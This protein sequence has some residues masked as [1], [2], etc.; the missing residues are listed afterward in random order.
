MM[1]ALRDNMK[2]I[3]WITAVIF[4]VGFGILE[5][6]G[7]LDQPGNL[8][9]E[10]GVIAKV[11]G[12]P[13][14]YDEFMQVYNRMIQDLTAQ[15]PLQEG[16]DSL[17]REQAWQQ[18]VRNKLMEQ[19]ARRRGIEVTPDEIKTAIRLTPPD[20]LMQ[21]PAFQTD[22]Q[23]DYRKYLGELDN[24]N[25]QLP[26]QQV[27]AVVAAAL[28]TQ[29]LQDQIVAAAKVSEGDVRDRFLLEREQL[30]LR[31]LAFSPDSFQ[32]DTTRIGGADIENYYKAH[33][34]EFTGPQEVKVQ[35]LLAPRLPG[36]ADF[37]AARERLQGILD[38]LRAEPDSFESFARTY[39]DIQSAAAGGDPG[40][41]PYLD[42]LRPIFRNAL[43]TV[44]EGDLSPILQEVRSLHIFRVDRR[45][46]D[47]TTRR[48]RI[49]YHEIAV[50]VLPG[51][52]SIRAARE[53]VAQIQKEAKRQGLSPVATRRGL[54]TFESAFFAQGRSQTAVFQ[55]FPEVELW[56]FR[57][58]VGDVS[59]P[60][61]AEAGWYLYE[62]LDRRNAGKRTLDAVREA[63]KIALIRSLKTAKAEEAA[64]QAWASIL[65]GMPEEEAAR[66]HGGRFIVAEAVK[67]NGIIQGFGQDPRSVGRLFTLPV[68]T[69]SPVLTG[70]QGVL[71]AYVESHTTP[72]EEEFQQ[73]A[74][75]IR[76]NLLYERRQVTL[77]EWMREMRLRAKIDDY[78]E[79]Y[80]EA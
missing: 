57:A 35:V 58:K 13:I 44:K 56:C 2:V 67:Q 37:A 71:A 42:E 64:A 26:W 40:G 21:A 54:R 47:E 23:F 60:V 52:E 73:Q 7:V 43:R 46:P 61:P 70:P 34:D 79:N 72:T 11:N 50:R 30:K 24:P 53:Q 39:S 36:E 74:A 16:E 33:P 19:E 14:R 62:I 55:Q 65:A 9:G 8:Q 15:R 20:F 45:Y 76:Q 68:G 4:L 66:R 49:K 77:V 1:Q 51:T 22:G 17:V 28:P 75:T 63:A 10:R 6:G 25:S 31:V 5:L 41:E 48:E 59:R 29:K 38:Q 3:I 69:W 32:V 18:I 80:F 78:R 12:E 27:E